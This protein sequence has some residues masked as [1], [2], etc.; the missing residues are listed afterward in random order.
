MALVVPLLAWMPTGTD[1]QRIPF[2]VQHPEV[3]TLLLPSSSSHFVSW[4]TVCTHQPRVTRRASC[5]VLGNLS[6][7]AESR[8]LHGATLPL[9]TRCHFTCSTQSAKNSPSLHPPGISDLWFVCLTGQGQPRINSQLCRV[10]QHALVGVTC[11][12][13]YKY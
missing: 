8:I 9:P 4:P 6:L 12:N 2:A 11:T 1:T 10:S 5:L 7:K 3:P 13:E